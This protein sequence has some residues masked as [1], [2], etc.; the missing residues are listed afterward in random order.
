MVER[1]YPGTASP[2]IGR[3]LVASS[4]Q[5]YL[6]GVESLRVVMQSLVAG[7]KLELACRLWRESDRAVVLS[8]ELIDSGTGIPTP[9]TTEYAL[10]AGALLN[11]RLGVASGT[12]AHGAIWVRVQLIQGAGAAAVVV[13]TLLQGFV[14]TSNDLGW[15]GSPIEKQDSASGFVASH[16]GAAGAN[17]SALTIGAR[18]RW[19]PICGRFTY[20]ASGAAGNRNAFVAVL[21]NA[22][23]FVYVGVSSIL[24]GPGGALSLSFAA[25]ASPSADGGGAQFH[26][27]FPGDLELAGGW[28]LRFSALGADVADVISNPYFVV[29]KRVDDQP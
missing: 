1:L 22:G 21:D 13:G 6:T 26:L 9:V 20:T 14:S 7:V 11:V 4:F 5:Y 18:E 19:R 25:G 16:A 3:G 8:R 24:I 17:I 28:G 15:P 10:D 23:N 2:I 29:R 27:P 12:P